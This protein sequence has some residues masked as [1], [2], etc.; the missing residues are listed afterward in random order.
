MIV[1]CKGELKSAKMLK[2]RNHYVPIGAGEEA[3]MAAASAGV[4]PM[5]TAA[6]VASVISFVVAAG[7]YF[8]FIPVFAQLNNQG[9][10][11]RR[12]EMQ[13]I[14]DWRSWRIS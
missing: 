4:S 11:I 2:H 6:M 9:A 10:V 8:I 5:M 7:A 3:G 1:R 13:P 14:S 12:D